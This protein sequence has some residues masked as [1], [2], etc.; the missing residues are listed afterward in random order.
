MNISA[1]D[2]LWTSYVKRKFNS[3]FFKNIENVAS[4]YERAAFSNIF[5]NNTLQNTPFSV[6]THSMGGA[7]LPE[8][9]DNRARARRFGGL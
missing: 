9:M 7:S 2:F 8:W 1:L 6:S 3:L 5:I 4:H